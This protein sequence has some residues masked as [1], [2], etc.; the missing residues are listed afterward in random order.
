MRGDLLSGEQSER[1]CTH[2]APARLCVKGTKKLPPSFASIV[3]GHTRPVQLW[4]FKMY[5]WGMVQDA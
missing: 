5:R 2:A 4:E 1:D 3:P